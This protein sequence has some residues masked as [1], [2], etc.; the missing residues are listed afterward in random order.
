MIYFTQVKRRAFVL[1][2]T[3]LSVGA[4]FSPFRPQQV[5][6]NPSS[7]LL[8]QGRT[9]SL[10][11]AGASFPA[12]LYTQ[13]FSEYN[14]VKPNIQ[15]SYQSVG[16]GAGV[17][18]F[19]AGTVD[20]GASDVAMTD[21]EMAKVSKGVVLLPMT[22]GSI[23]LAY[24]VPGV[25]SLKLS[26]QAYSGIF[27]GK[28]RKWND[29][30]ITKLNPGVRFPNLPIQVIHRSDGSGTTAVF[31]K[32]LSAIS[33]AWR[34]SPG[35]GK[36]VQ[37]P[38]GAGAKG[39]EGV[40]AQI[41][42]ARGSIGYVEYAYAKNNNL[43]TAALQNKSGKYVEGN[44]KNAAASL[45]SIKLPGNLRAFVA[46][47]GGSNSYPIVTYSWILAYKNYGNPTKAKALKDAMKWGL[48]QGQKNAAQLGYIPLPQNVVAKV[49]LAID[50]IK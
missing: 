7:T 2:L 42:Q 24:N 8:A 4:A 19:S 31:T 3:A 20:F 25:R 34:S 27:L 41:Q 37:W 38:V 32:H 50:T 48:T 16:S 23:V 6:A 18:Q 15:I 26:R 17:K 49:R 33:S 45:A 10:I 35:E 13:W 44:L 36:S 43:P 1:G 47:P 5:T 40:T 28:I 11:G 39:N 30:A 29:P 12:P 21:Q 22:A 46:D 9:V 14:R